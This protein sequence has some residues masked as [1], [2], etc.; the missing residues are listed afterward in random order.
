MSTAVSNDI[1][2]QRLLSAIYPAVSS[3]A[4]DDIF[5]WTSQDPRDSQLFN[6]WGVAYRFQTIVNAN[7][8]SVTT[9]WRMIRPNR[10]DR[11]AKFEWASTGCLGRI[12]I[13]K[14]MLPMADL[15]RPDPSIQGARIFA[16]PDGCQ[17]RWR[18]SATNSDILL[19]DSNGEVIAF[20]RPT[21]R[22]RY[23]LG[24]VYGE[25]HFLRNAGAGTVMHPPIMDTVT[26]TIMLYRFCAEWNL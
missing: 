11:V 15:V 19:Q 1:Q 10:E 13:G 12:I 24:D 22:T 6:S 8:K 26:V 25:L 17:Y 23:Q 21:K 9:L 20:F 5:S 18:P 16:G 3:A 7:G 14:N 4:S 2:P